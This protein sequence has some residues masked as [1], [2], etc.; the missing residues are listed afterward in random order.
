[1]YVILG[2]KVDADSRIPYIKKIT[3]NTYKK[4]HQEKII[5]LAN[6]IATTYSAYSSYPAVADAPVA[7]LVPVA[8]IASAFSY[9]YPAYTSYSAPL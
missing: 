3:R 5:D 1:M 9:S 8:P 2:L 4:K 6:F 7:S